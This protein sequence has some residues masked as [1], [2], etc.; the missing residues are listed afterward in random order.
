M[1]NDVLNI[2]GWI[3]GTWGAMGLAYAGM[4]IANVIRMKKEQK[5][6]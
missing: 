1:N 2:L 4:N 5:Q 3:V 6:M